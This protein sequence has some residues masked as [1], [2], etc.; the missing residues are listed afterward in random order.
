MRLVCNKQKH[1]TLTSELIVKCGLFADMGSSPALTEFRARGK[2]LHPRTLTPVMIL[3][4]DSKFLASLSV[5]D[6]GVF[7]QVFQFLIT[8]EIQEMLCYA[9]SMA[10]IGSRNHFTYLEQLITQQ[11]K[12]ARG[13]IVGTQL[14]SN[15]HHFLFF[16]PQPSRFK[17]ISKCTCI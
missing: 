13:R 1:R 5:L 15:Q 17:L 7:L 4:A 16:S 9:S 10:L 11:R 6:P 8:E 14:P 2:G 12:N 3:D